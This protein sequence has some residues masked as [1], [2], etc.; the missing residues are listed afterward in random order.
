MNV[1]YCFFFD[2]QAAGDH[3]LSILV[4]RLADGVDGFPDRRVDEAA[5][6]HDDEVSAGVARRGRVAFGAKLRE[7]ALGIDERFRAA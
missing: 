5:G 6:V 1:P 3:H 2:P 4:E 7:D